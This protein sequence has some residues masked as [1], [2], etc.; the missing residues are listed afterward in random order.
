MAVRLPTVLLKNSV[1]PSGDHEL[2][3]PVP[4]KVRID[5]G[6]ALPSAGIHQIVDF[7]PFAVAAKVIRRPSGRPDRPGTPAGVNQPYFGAAFAIDNPNGGLLG[8]HIDRD[9]TPIG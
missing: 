5:S 3:V 6:L 2:G 9:Q 7:V 8:Y 1:F 4:S